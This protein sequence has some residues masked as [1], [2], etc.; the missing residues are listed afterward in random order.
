MYFEFDFVFILTLNT[1]RY[2]L[3]LWQVQ[4]CGRPEAL[5]RCSRAWSWGMTEAQNHGGLLVIQGCQ[6]PR[7]TEVSLV[8]VQGIDEVHHTSLK[9]GAMLSHWC[10]SKSRG[11]VLVTSLEYGALEVCMMLTFIVTGPL[12]ESRQS[13]VLT[14]LSFPHVDSIFHNAVLPGVVK[15]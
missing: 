10:Q 12:L 14:S 11:L 1:L 2:L 4:H 6:K 3:L 5:G 13:P 9:S 8:L 15:G 7:A